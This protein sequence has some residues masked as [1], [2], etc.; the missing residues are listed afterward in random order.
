MTLV[1]SFS[2]LLHDNWATEAIVKAF[3]GLPIIL[4]SAEH[5]FVISQF[6]Q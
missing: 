3:L 1:T 2:N 4:V 6:R 5:L